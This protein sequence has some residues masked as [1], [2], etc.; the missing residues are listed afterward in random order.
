MALQEGINSY[1]T[2]EDADT[3]LAHRADDAEW[4]AATTSA[5]EDA[6]VTATRFIDENPWVGYAVSAS[7]ALGWPRLQAKHYDSKLG[8]YVTPADD[9]IPSRLKQAVAELALY[10][11][12]NPGVYQNTGSVPESITVGPISITDTNSRTKNATIPGA[13]K[14]MIRPLLKKGVTGGQGWWR[15]N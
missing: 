9:E 5:K 12:Q 10:F 6:L 7:Q 15:A 2:A 11:I 13:V 8:L 14:S 3:L 1:I 4:T